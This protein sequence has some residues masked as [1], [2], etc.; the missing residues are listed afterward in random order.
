LKDISEH[1]GRG[2]ST[3]YYTPVLPFPVNI[4]H[5]H[6]LYCHC[7]LANLTSQTAKQV[8]HTIISM[9]LQKQVT[10]EILHLLHSILQAISFAPRDSDEENNPNL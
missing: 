4:N 3:S 7:W 10:R 8:K 9:V 1:K 6:K 5:V 2:V